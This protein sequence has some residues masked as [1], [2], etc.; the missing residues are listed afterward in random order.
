[1]SGNIEDPQLRILGLGTARVY[2]DQKMLEAADWTYAKP[3]ELLFLLLCGSDL[4]KEQIG[5][6][7]WPWASAA[8]LRNSFHTTLHH[9][10]RALGSPDWVI[11]QRGRY[12][13]NRSLPYTFDVEA[14]LAG[15][16]RAHEVPGEAVRCLTRAVDLYRGDFLADLPGEHWIDERRSGLQQSYEHALLTLGQLHT[17]AGNLAEAVETYLRVIAHDS[18]LETGHR[19]LIRCYARLGEHGR[20]LRQYQNLATML[21]DEL[22][23][24]PSPQTAALNSALR[25]GQPI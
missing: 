18:L 3:R 9:L 19:E 11:Y 10:R 5:A 1:M 15:L 8:R 21:R 6:A 14:F 20:A 23:V 24:G 7:L 25:K 22:G 12:A 4:T 13:F 16:A 17:A 2:R